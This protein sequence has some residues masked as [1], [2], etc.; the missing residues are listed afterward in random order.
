LRPTFSSKSKIP[1]R[2][3]TKRSSTSAPTCLPTSITTAIP[4]SSSSIHST[5]VPLGYYTVCPTNLHTFCPSKQSTSTPTKS[6]LDWVLGYTYE[7]C[8]TTCSRMTSK[9]CASSYFYTIYNESSY[10]NMLNSAIYVDNNHRVLE[11][12]NFSQYCNFL[13]KEY[14]SYSGFPDVFVTIYANEVFMDITHCRYPDGLRNVVADCNKVTIFPPVS[15][16]CPC[17]GSCNKVDSLVPTSISTSGP[18]FSSKSKIPSR[19]PTKRYSTS[20]P[21]SIPTSIPS[22]VLRNSLLLLLQK[23]V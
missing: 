11:D 12:K 23:N 20:T 1:S 16:F 21:A 9:T 15:R 4:S 19:F 13:N 6:C 10:K 5:L 2:L 3:P 8:T 14:E 22:S 7:S 17:I 18:T